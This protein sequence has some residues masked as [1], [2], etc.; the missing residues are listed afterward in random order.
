MMRNMLPPIRPEVTAS[1][2]KNNSNW[3]VKDADPIHGKVSS[4]LL[5]EF[6]S[7]PPIVSETYVEMKNTV[8]PND[9]VDPP[10]YHD[11]DE[12]DFIS[13]LSEHTRGIIDDTVIVYDKIDKRKPAV[14]HE[15][16]LLKTQN[17][18]VLIMKLYNN[19]PGITDLFVQNK[20]SM[21]TYEVE[22]YKSLTKVV[23]GVKTNRSA[24]L[25][26]DIV[27][28]LVAP[29]KFATVTTTGR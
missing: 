29:V 4:V 14:D 3:N 25:N 13:P 7:L 2:V 22:A 15:Q 5:T 12:D 17:N 20:S 9:K 27:Q 19:M 24:L 21:Q 11:D 28:C 26:E 23:S 8:A 6:T 10:R 16:Q 1:T 18:N